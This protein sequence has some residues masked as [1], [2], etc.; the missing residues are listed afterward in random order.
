MSIAQRIFIFLMLLNSFII[1]EE[2]KATHIVGGELNYQYLGNNIYRIW[3]TVYRDCY[4]GVPP[5]DNP[6]SIGVFDA[7]NNAL[8]F[9][10]L[11]TRNPSDTIPPTINSPCFIPPTN[12][13]YERSS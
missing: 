12:V 9:E 8:I 6:A 10:R 2:A 4:N 13:C 3:L 5:F 1:S 7:G 11:L